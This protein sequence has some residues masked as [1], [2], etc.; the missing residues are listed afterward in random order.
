MK[1]LIARF[2][3]ETPIFWKKFR[4]F[5][6]WLGG[7]VAA[8]WVINS[9]LGLDLPIAIIAICK[10]ILAMCAAVTGSSTLTVNNPPTTNS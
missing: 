1:E 3:A 4:A 9:T 10:Y 6:M 8:V 2:K 5:A 7:S